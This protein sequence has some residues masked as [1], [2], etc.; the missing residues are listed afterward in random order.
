DVIQITDGFSGAPVWDKV[1]QRVIGMIAIATNIHGATFA[2][3]TEILQ[4]VCPELRPSDICPYRNLLAFTEN[5]VNFFFGRERV[6]ER[7][8]RSLHADSRVLLVHG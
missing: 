8:L 5:D 1:R 7:L 4:S 6:V 3:P 2:I